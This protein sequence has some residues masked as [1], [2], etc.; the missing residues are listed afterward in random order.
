VDAWEIPRRHR[1]AVRLLTPADTFPFAANT[2]RSTQI[3]HTIAYAHDGRRGQ[4]RVGNPGPMTG[5][6]Y[7]IET[8]GRWAVRQP[9]PGLCVW[10]DPDGATALVDHSGTRRVPRDGSGSPVDPSELVLAS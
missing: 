10:R 5:L 3:D 9:F 1:E 4:S 7:R 2:T 6:H 8:H